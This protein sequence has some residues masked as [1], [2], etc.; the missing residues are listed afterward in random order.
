MR[1]VAATC[2]ARTDVT[3]AEYCRPYLIFTRS[4]VQKFGIVPCVF[5]RMAHPSR[6]ERGDRAALGNDHA[7][8][9]FSFFVHHFLAQATLGGKHGGARNDPDIAL[10]IG[11]HRARLNDRLVVGQILCWHQ[12]NF[13][14]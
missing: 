3:V 14:G 13:G 9:D 10:E 2:F 5:V 6:F 11:L 12:C 7:F 8:D 1:P 4:I